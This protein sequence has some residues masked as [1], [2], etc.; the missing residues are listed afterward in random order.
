MSD[1]LAVVFD[2][3]DTLVPDST[4]LLLKQHG[5]DPDKF[6]KKD[7]EALVKQGYDPTL[8]FLRL[9]LD[10]VG[11]DKPLGLLSN[12]A[13]GK[14]GKTLDSHFY[15][16]IPA[17]FSDLRKEVARQSNKTVSIEFY[18]VSGGLQAVIEGATFTSKYFTGIYG[19][20]LGE[21]GNPPVIRN[22]KRSINF[23][24]KTRYLFEIN[25][26]I[27]AAESSQN[28]YLVNREVSPE[29]RHIPFSNM[30]YVGDGITDIPCFSLLKH[31]GGTPF[32][33]FD[34]KNPAKAK[35]A[36]VDFLKPGRVVGMHAPKYR[37]G[38]EL[39]ELLRATVATITTR[40]L[41]DRGVA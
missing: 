4:T 23:T 33:V 5:I 3:D 37:R 16:G 10:N 13:L 28:P 1:T 20:Q 35:R 34:P 25:K 7:L 9:F 19:C 21:E 8:G 17:L 39:G 11:K 14:F 36:F 15:P 24:E 6:W 2:F 29:K 38:T 31:F 26:G 18:I 22:I 41:I 30:V 40:I 32:G 12:D 27:A